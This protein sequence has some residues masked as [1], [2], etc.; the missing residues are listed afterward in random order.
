MIDRAC[1]SLNHRCNLR[2]Q[3]C[4]FAGKH[5]SFEQDNMEFDRANVEVVVDNIAEYC[6][7]K[8]ICVFKLGIVGAG[9]PLLSFATITAIV[10]C[11]KN[12][13][14]GLFKI[15]TITNGVGLT[16]E[17]LDFFNINS[18]IID[19]NF[20]LDGY[21]ELHNAYRQKFCATMDSIFRYEKLFGYKPIINCTVSKQSFIHQDKLIRFFAENH[22]DRINFSI[23]SEIDD[24]NLI[25]SRQEYDAFLDKCETAGISMRQKS[26]TINSVYDCTMYGRLCGVGRTN[27]FFTRDGIYPCGRFF[28]LEQY[29]IAKFDEKL[30]EIESKLTMLKN[31]SNNECYYETLKKVV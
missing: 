1:I 14:D 3:Y 31:V 7:Q 21:E 29:R 22:F 23:I 28:G 19:I 4:H 12:K 20:S 18:N 2:C 11:A 6:K 9:E 26:K 25:L 8:G 13:R 15:Y 30:E 17:Q 10:D 24:K 16:D 5:T 27:I